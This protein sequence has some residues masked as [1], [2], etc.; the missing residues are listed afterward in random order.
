M[1]LLDPE[2]EYIQHFCP[3][4]KRRLGAGDEAYYHGDP[5]P[6]QHC[7]DFPLQFL[8]KEGAQG[9]R[10]SVRQFLFAKGVH[11]NLERAGEHA[12]PR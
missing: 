5:N 3:K 10:N 4:L 1:T 11:Q 9:Q 2:A 7:V 6:P 8:G 12:Q